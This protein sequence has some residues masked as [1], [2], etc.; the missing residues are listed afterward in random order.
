MRT[1]VFFIFIA[2]CNRDCGSKEEM[3]NPDYV[4]VYGALGIAL[5][6]NGVVW[7][8]VHTMEMLQS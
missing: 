7:Y 5:A 2:L 4:S 6:G 8:G 1:S 3:S